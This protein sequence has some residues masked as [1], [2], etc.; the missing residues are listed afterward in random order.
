[1]L[2]DDW[3]RFTGKLTFVK[4]PKDNEGKGMCHLGDSIE[5]QANEVSWGIKAF[6]AGKA[7]DEATPH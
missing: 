7:L 6:V 3:Q 4:V 2:F 5:Q 1:M